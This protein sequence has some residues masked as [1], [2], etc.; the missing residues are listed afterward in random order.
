MFSIPVRWASW[1]ELILLQMLVPQSSWLGHLCGILTGGCSAA[2]FCSR[3]HKRV[4]SIPLT[5]GLLYT[6]GALNFLVHPHLAASYTM[7]AAPRRR[8]NDARGA[9]GTR[10]PAVPPELGGADAAPAEVPGRE[11]VEAEA[12][13]RSPMFSA[14]EVRQHRLRRFAAAPPTAPATQRRPTT[15]RPPRFF[16]TGQLGTT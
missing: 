11:P 3:T 2:C 1:F 7:F 5:V 12:E 6:R 16:G 10:T 14:D 8:Y 9:T 15:N 4:R 13:Q